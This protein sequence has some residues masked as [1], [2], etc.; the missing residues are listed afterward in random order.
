[1]SET[2]E[3]TINIYQGADQGYKITLTLNGAEWNITGATAARVALKRD[4]SDA[5]TLFSV[6]LLSTDVGSDW[7]HGIIVFW[8]SAAQAKLVTGD[9]RW[10]CK[11][12][13]SG[14]RHCPVAGPALLTRQV[15]D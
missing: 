2:V 8:I 7:A 6:T 4:L 10:D 3:A 5:A 1:M 14:K 12:T 11:F 15:D 9:G 13:L